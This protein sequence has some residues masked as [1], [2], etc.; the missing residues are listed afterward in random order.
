[1]KAAGEVPTKPMAVSYRE[2]QRLLGV[3]ETTLKQMVAR[4]VISERRYF[5]GAHPK[6]PMSEIE[7]LT[8]PGMPIQKDR[9]GVRQR[10]ETPTP[11]KLVD[12]ELTKLDAVAKSRRK[13]RR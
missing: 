7:R 8:L 1:M 9:S 3:G 11:R 13:K 12:A 10:R 5:D 6:I 4:G 2:A